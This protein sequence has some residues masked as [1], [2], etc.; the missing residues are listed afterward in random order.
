VNPRLRTTALEIHSGLTA[1]SVCLFVCN[2]I[3]FDYA[4]SSAAAA[5]SHA[6][7]RTAI[8]WILV[9]G[10]RFGEERGGVVSQ[11]YGA[12]TLR[13]KYYTDVVYK[14]AALQIKSQNLPTASY[15]LPDP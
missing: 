7:T 3:S 11:C 12:G 15:L 6:V 2:F 4:S 10:D 9:L 14:Q 13:L 8:M 5:F 1:Y